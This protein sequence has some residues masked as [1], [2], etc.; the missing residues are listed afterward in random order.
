MEVK[1]NKSV[2]DYVKQIERSLTTSD[3]H[4]QGKGGLNNPRARA[5]R[6]LSWE[7]LARKAGVPDE[8]ISR[9]RKEFTRMYGDD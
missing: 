5:S 9:V 8:T 1:P 2:Y 4:T 7:R 3:R 6:L